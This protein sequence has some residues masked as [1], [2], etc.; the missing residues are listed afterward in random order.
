MKIYKMDFLKK[1]MEK[2]GIGL[3]KSKKGQ[4]TIFI[5]AAIVIVVAGILIYLFYPDIRSGFAV[6][7]PTP[8]KFIRDCMEKESVEIIN[9][10]SMQGG[11]LNPQNYYKHNNYNSEYLCYTNEDYKNCVMQQPMLKEHIEKEI[12]SALASKAD[13]C[14]DS[15]KEEYENS[16]YQVNMQKNDLNVELLPKR[17]ELNLNAKTS[18]VKDGTQNYDSFKF[19][20]NNNLYE[21]VSIA[22]SILNWEARYGDSETTTYMTYYPEMK[23]EKLKQTDGTTVYIISDREGRGKLQFASRSVVFPSGY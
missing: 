15:L 11:S 22:N 13:E 19:T 1:D 17:I 7:T 18:F 5:I 21:I 10:I 3:Q 23:V 9:T 2:E 14:L 6:E 4:V 16:G 8:E 20:V 12:E